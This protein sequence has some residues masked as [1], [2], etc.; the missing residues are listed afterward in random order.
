MLR[1]MIVEVSDGGGGGVR[2]RCGGL[3]WRLKG[4]LYFNWL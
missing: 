4:L 1:S 2:E 3:G